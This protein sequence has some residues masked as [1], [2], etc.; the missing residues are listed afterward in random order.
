MAFFLRAVWAEMALPKAKRAT[1]A[2]TACRKR[3]VRVSGSLIVSDV[4]AVSSFV[5]SARRRRPV[6]IVYDVRR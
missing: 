2:C 5:H 3:Q 1:V 6:R 4:A